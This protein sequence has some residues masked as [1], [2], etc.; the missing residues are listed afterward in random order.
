M[1]GKSVINEVENMCKELVVA[2]FEIMF[3][4]LPEGTEENRRKIIQVSLSAGRDLKTG[5]SDYD[6]L[7]VNYFIE[8]QRPRNC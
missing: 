7:I 3:R 4:N 5:P 1:G 8:N 2:Y 6:A